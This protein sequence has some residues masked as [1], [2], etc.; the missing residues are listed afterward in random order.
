MKDSHPTSENEKEYMRI[1]QEEDMKRY[2]HELELKKTDHLNDILSHHNVATT[3][4]LTKDLMEWAH[5]FPP[6]PHPPSQPPSKKPNTTPPATGD[7]GSGHD[8]SGPSPGSSSG[9]S[10]K[11]KKS[12]S[13]SGGKS[14]HDVKETQSK[15]HRKVPRHE[16]ADEEEAR[17]REHGNWDWSRFR[18]SRDEAQ[19]VNIGNSKLK[20]TTSKKSNSV[21]GGKSR[22]S[23]PDRSISQLYEDLAHST[24]VMP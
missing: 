11:S 8:D 17:Q 2:W 9:S 14:T 16:P 7:R 24:T 3:K 5:R 18:M 19:D 22:E 20:K 6:S 10:G 21:S 12:S 15:K 23:E 4:S 1:K 13:M